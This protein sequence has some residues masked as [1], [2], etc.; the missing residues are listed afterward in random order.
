MSFILTYKSLQRQYKINA[1]LNDYKY[2]YVITQKVRFLTKHECAV[3]KIKPRGRTPTFCEKRQLE[4][5][6]MLR[7][8]DIISR[9]PPP[10][11]S[12]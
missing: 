1:I 5:T 11:P 9:P 2:R 12:T 7:F 6:G 10:L 8:Q 4:K 3:L